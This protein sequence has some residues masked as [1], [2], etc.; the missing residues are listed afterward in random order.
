M[1]ACHKRLLT[2]FQK[3][4]SW[5]ERKFGT[6]RK[7]ANSNVIDALLFVTTPHTLPQVI[8]DLKRQLDTLLTEWKPP[9]VNS[10]NTGMSSIRVC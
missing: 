1:F 4:G 2:L 7:G 8:D 5:L 10:T 3:V 9:K 6:Q